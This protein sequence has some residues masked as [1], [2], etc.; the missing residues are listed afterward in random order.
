M[1]KAELELMLNSKDSEIAWLGALSQATINNK[2]LTFKLHTK[3]NFNHIIM[4]NVFSV[5]TFTYL[6]S[7]NLESIFLFDTFDDTEYI[8]GSEN[9]CE[10]IL[11]KYFSDLNYRILF[12]FV[13]IDFITT[14]K[15]DYIYKNIEKID[16]FFDDTSNFKD[17]KFDFN[18]N[19][20]ISFDLIINNLDELTNICSTHIDYKNSFSLTNFEINYF[21]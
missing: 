19:L 1:K 5:N 7:K 10:N 13:E 6:T 18:N 4:A 14:L 12:K 20:S 11:I 16:E 8:N 2:S 9:T 21:S 15:D 3:F 17:I